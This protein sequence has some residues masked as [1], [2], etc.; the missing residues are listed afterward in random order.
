[1]TDRNLSDYPNPCAIVGTDGS[2]VLVGHPA[3]PLVVLRRS[4]DDTL[5]ITL[6]HGR[7][8]LGS[9]TLTRGADGTYA[10]TCSEMDAVWVVSGPWRRLEF[11][12]R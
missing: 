3:Q 2:G 9:G 8:P 1:M 11:R 6:R 5:S 10:G 12:E 4:G 7:A